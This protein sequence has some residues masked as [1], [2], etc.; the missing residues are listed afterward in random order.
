MRELRLIKAAHVQASTGQT[1]IVEPPKWANYATLHFN[2]IT[3]AGTTNLTDLALKYVN[4]LITLVPVVATSQAGGAGDDEVQTITLT[5]GPTEGTF[6]ISWGGVSANVSATTAP[7][8]ATAT[9]DAVT[10]ALKAALANTIYNDGSNNE[11]VAV[12]TGAGTSGDPYVHTLTFS[13]PLVDK[14]NVD[15]VTVDGTSLYNYAASGIDLAGWNGITQIVET[16]AANVVVQLGPGVT[17]IADDDTGPLYSVNCALPS[18]FAA[19]ITL[20][21]ADADETYT[22]SLYADYSS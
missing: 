6:T 10:Q 9:G 1:T 3:S 8:P 11:I 17:G 21:R 7:I 5:G 16:T 15:A 20:D 22:Y 19:V 14:T 18:R 2:V 12:R 4:P 13:G